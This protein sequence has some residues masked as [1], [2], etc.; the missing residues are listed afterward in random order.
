ML[1]VNSAMPVA[2]PAAS[3]DW[4]MVQLPRQDGPPLRF[5]GRQRFE[6]SRGDLSVSLWERKRGGFVVSYT[7]IVG[8][9][10]RDDAASVATL[11]DVADHLEML[12][13]APWEAA[14]NV[15]MPALPLAGTLRHMQYHHTF[16]LLVGDVLASLDQQILQAEASLSKGRRHGH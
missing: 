6:W 8:D 5:K 10:L 1:S 9:L 16:P 12:C 4:V 3:A 2:S 15:S 11:I 13:Q 7:V 14:V